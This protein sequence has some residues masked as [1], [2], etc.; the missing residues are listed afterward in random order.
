MKKLKLFSCLLAVVLIAT[1]AVPAAFA[2]TYQI[3]D[4]LKFQLET[5]EVY[6]AGIEDDRTTLDV[7]SAMNGYPVTAT[8]MDFAQNNANLESVTFANAENI[9][10]IGSYG[11]YNCTNLRTVNLGSYVTE[12]YRGVFRGCTSLETVELSDKITEIPY[13]CFYGCTSLGQITLDRN[14]T[15]IQSNSFTGCPNLRIRCYTDS[16]AHHF[17]VDN[18][19]AYILIDGALLGDTNGDGSVNINDVTTIQRYL[20]EL[21]SLEGI[22]LH[23]ADANQDG[24]VDIADATTLQMYLAEYDI[25]Y[26]IGEVMTQ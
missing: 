23:A 8:T 25:P 6:L 18:K 26:P 13:E 21:E 5:E 7:P 19:I 11:F 15:S 3:S 4:G 10:I 1:A 17:A 22:Y 14:I 12:L 16:Y 2:A 20:A 24:T 9:S